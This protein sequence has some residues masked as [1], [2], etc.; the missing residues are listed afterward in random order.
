[1]VDDRDKYLRLDWVLPSRSLATHA[2]SSRKRARAVASTAGVYPTP[3]QARWAGQP[4]S[5]S[6]RGGRVL[7]FLA[8]RVRSLSAYRI[9]EQL[10]AALEDKAGQYQRASDSGTGAH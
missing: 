5:A 9:A 7:P 1:V 2:Q 3:V 4:P 10:L 8:V 6:S